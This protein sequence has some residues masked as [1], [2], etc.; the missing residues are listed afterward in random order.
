MRPGGVESQLYNEVNDCI[1]R[2]WPSRPAATSKH[3]AGSRGAG[4][5]S[6]QDWQ[7]LSQAL[8]DNGFAGLP[9]AQPAGGTGQALLQGLYE[10][11][12]SV[13][14]HYD[15]RSQLVKELLSA[16]D[17]AREREAREEGYFKKLTR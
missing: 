13:L 10:A 11:C 15:R 12:S 5:I 9:L 17:L 6:Q 16:A 8:R 1:S 3:A 4:P 7:F 14:K 2:R